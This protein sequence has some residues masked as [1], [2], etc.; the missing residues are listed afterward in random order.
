[1]EQGKCTGQSRKGK[2]LNKEERVVVERMSRAGYPARDIAEVL[3]R[4]RRTIERE[5]ARG[6]VEH[7]DSEWRVKMVYSSDRGQD[8]H[9]LNATA[10]GYQLKLGSNHDLVEFVRTRIIDQREAPAVVAFRMREAKM[11]GAICTKTIYNYIDQGLIEGVTNESLWEKRKRRKR[12]RHTL[13]RSRKSPTRRL[14]IEKRPEQV[15]QREE[16]GHWE[17]DLV[18]GPSGTKA[19]LMTLVERKTRNLIIRKLPDKTHATVRRALNAIERSSG[20]SGFREQFKSITADNGSEFLDVDGLQKSVLSGH[21]RTAVF[22]AHPYA[23][24][25]RGTNEN[26][27]RIIRRFIAKGRQIETLNHCAIRTIEKWINNYPR[28]ILNFQ[29][30]QQCFTQ[31][32][33]DI[34]A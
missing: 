4:H 32:T 27:N 24:W 10:K 13:R 26:T 3:G 23:S 12:Q 2:H 21:L 11:A 1:M 30:P 16:F 34:A 28:Q 20:A 7:K 18:V 29:S 14:S 6:S 5:I 15:N 9:D 31:E 22:Y 33:R 8:L 19:A 25:E 17:I